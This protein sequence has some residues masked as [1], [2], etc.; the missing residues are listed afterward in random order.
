MTPNQ[1]RRPVG[2]DEYAS[3]VRRV[4]RAHARRVATGD[5][6]ALVDMTEPGAALDEAITQA[7]PGLRNAGDRLK[8]SGQRAVIP[9]HLY[10]GICNDTAFYQVRHS[11]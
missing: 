11:S 4:M 6:D 2:N 7:V 1:R 3:F 5:V 9:T 8:Q 10:C